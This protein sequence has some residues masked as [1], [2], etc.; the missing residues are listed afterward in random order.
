MQVGTIVAVQPDCKNGIPWF[1]K[2]TTIKNKHVE[3]IW[4][5][6]SKSNSKYFYLSKTTDKISKE[7][8]ICHGIDFEPCFEDGLLWHLLTPLPFI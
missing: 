5:H 8:I 6:K 2:V 3:V 1:R 4:L 7:T